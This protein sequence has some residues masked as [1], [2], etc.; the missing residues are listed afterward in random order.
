MKQ[1]IARALL[2]AITVVTAC[3]D[4]KSPTTPYTSTTAA[5][6]SARAPAYSA[7]HNARRVAF[8]FNGTASGFPIGAVFLSGGGSFDPSSASNTIPTETDVHSG[9]GFSCIDG[10]GQ[11]P[12]NHCLTGEGVR[13]DTAQL[14]ASAPFKCTATDAVKTAV[15]GPGRV[16]LQAD[17]YRAGD[18][19]EESFR[20]QMIVSET[21]LA[22]NIPGEQTLWIQ[23]VGCGTAKVNFN[24]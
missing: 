24:G 15:T 17:F 23:G 7:A 22:P 21:D 4:Y 6:D 12:L 11:G 10:V 14:L 3:G 18:G 19:N 13:W 20:A 2:V 16:V 5:Q 9:G 8:G 1:H